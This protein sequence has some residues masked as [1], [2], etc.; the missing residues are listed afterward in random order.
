MALRWHG[1]HLHRQ[2]LLRLFREFPFRLMALTS[3]HKSGAKSMTYW[4]R[5]HTSKSRLPILFIHGI[6]IGLYPYV[7]CLVELNQANENVALD[8]DVGIIALE[9]MPISFRITNQ[10]LGKDETCAE[11]KRILKT[12]GWDKVVLVSHSFGSVITTHLLKNDETSQ[13]IGPVLLIDPVSILLH[14]PDVAY[15]FTYRK[16]KRANEHLL[17]Y[18]ASMDMGVSHTLARRFFWSENILWKH[19][20]EGRRVTVSLAGRDLIV[21]AETVAR[22]LTQDHLVAKDEGNWKQSAWQGKE[23][24]VL[25][26]D[27]LDHAQVFDSKK[28]RNILVQVIRAYCTMGKLDSVATGNGIAVSNGTTQFGSG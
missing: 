24:D 14:H 11:I 22:Y 9:I 28:D 7:N 6:G 1:F 13:K 20:I 5:H 19:D 16:P 12:H 15:N 27:R 8:G 18:F 21:N 17:Y 3:S 23:L 2:P 4:H 26:F 25:W 10:A